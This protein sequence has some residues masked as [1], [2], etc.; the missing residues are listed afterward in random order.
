MCDSLAH[1]TLGHLFKITVLHAVDGDSYEMYAASLE[2]LAA[3]P[4]SEFAR[5]VEAQIRERGML[6]AIE[7]LSA[8]VM[9]LDTAAALGSAQKPGQ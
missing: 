6:V 9:I 8:E 4:L 7:D 5:V 3:L 1:G 2:G